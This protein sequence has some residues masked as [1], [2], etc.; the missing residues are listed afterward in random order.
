MA[1]WKASEPIRRDD[2]C[3]KIRYTS[4]KIA[5]GAARVSR[6]KRPQ[7]R[8][9]DWTLAAYKCKVCGAWHIGHNRYMVNP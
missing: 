3:F 9:D 5:N 7:P 2:G 1:E 8:A 6:A 4:R